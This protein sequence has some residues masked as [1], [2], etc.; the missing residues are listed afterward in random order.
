ME[1]ENEKSD[2]AELPLL[3]R[4]SAGKLICQTCCRWRVERRGGGLWREEG[5][6]KV[7]TDVK[8]TI[9]II[10]T[11]FPVGLFST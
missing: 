1:D 4:V 5:W 7:D 10:L 8:S 3:L 11:T 2:G 9:I 6:K